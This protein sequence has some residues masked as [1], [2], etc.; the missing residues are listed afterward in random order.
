MI[1]PEDNSDQDEEDEE[2]TFVN[3][4]DALTMGP[5]LTVLFR[6][7]R[8]SFKSLHKIGSI[9]CNDGGDFATK[10]KLMVN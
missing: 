3:V 8:K 5:I 9:I 10:L 6:V 1:P 7:Y 4:C 2:A